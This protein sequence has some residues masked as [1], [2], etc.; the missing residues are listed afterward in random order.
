MII[1]CVGEVFASCDASIAK[2]YAWFCSLLAANAGTK[3]GKINRNI[4]YAIG[5]LAEHAQLL[6]SQSLGDFV[7]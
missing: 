1:G 6:F 5:I 7:V 4:A 3:D 2:H